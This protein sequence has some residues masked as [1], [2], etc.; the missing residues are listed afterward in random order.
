MSYSEIK[1]HNVECG[2]YASFFKVL[3]NAILFYDIKGCFN[4]KLWHCYCILLNA[5][6]IFI[7]VLD[8]LV[9]CKLLWL[10]LGLNSESFT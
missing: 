5:L 2:L 8:F 10:Q 6:V 4:F 1:I 3:I 7:K 9:Q